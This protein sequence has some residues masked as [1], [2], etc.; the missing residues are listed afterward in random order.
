MPNK[1]IFKII[2]LLVKLNKFDDNKILQ[3][4]KERAMETFKQMIMLKIVKNLLPDSPA[5]GNTIPF[6]K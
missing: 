4:L 3:V 2:H 1:D 6:A 5:Y